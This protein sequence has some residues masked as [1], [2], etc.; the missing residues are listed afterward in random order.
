MIFNADKERMIALELREKILALY[1][2]TLPIFMT[3]VGWTL[4][5]YDNA[6]PTPF[7]VRVQLDAYQKV[8]LDRLRLSEE[9]KAFLAATVEDTLSSGGTG[10]NDGSLQFDGSGGFSG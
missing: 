7:A 5:G 2:Q 10:L 6:L 9:V 4:N 1:S 8:E 3:V